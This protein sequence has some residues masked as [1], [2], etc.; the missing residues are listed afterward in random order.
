MQDLGG[1]TYSVADGINNSGQIVGV[2]TT[3]N[4]DLNAFLYSGGSMQDLGT[5]TGGTYSVATAI[6]DNGQIVGY[7]KTAAETSTPSFTTA[8]P[9]KTLAHL[10]D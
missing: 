10:G 6:S 9:F 8:G 3:S 1:G 7:A 2:A 4:G 5:L